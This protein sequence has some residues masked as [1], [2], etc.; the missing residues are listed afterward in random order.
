MHY[1]EEKRPDDNEGQHEM[2]EDSEDPWPY[3][4]SMGSTRRFDTKKKE[5]AVGDVQV[6]QLHPVRFSSRFRLQP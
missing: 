2:R 1:F 4:K 5:P 6:Y 3:K